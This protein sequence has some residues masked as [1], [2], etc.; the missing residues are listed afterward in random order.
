MNTEFPFYRNDIESTEDVE[1]E[2]SKWFLLN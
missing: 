1:T 2:I